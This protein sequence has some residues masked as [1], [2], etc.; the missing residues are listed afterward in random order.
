MNIVAFM[1]KNKMRTASFSEDA[2]SKYATYESRDKDGNTLKRA[3]TYPLAHAATVKKLDEIHDFAIR[4]ADS[5]GNA[6]FRFELGPKTWT[7][8]GVAAKVTKTP[9]SRADKLK[10]KPKTTTSIPEGKPS[11]KAPLRKAVRAMGRRGK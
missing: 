10:E 4:F 7:E 8:E 3:Y 11:S 9:Q 1:R 6:S 2:S 5:D